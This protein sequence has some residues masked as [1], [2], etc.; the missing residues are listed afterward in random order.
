MVATFELNVAG[1]GLDS[2]IFTTPISKS[3]RRAII[4]GIF[5]IN[6]KEEQFRSLGDLEAYFNDW[7]EEQRE[8]AAGHVLVVTHRDVL[9][10]ITHLRVHNPSRPSTS[11][12]LSRLNS[13]TDPGLL[14]AS[15]DLAARLWLSISIGSIQQALTPSNTIA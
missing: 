7:Y 5:D 13:S 15:I 6:L 10:I 3:L 14:V 1:G 11:D 8:V 12:D 2:K 9:D 4:N